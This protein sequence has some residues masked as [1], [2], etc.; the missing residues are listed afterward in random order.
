M[1]GKSLIVELYEQIV[2]Y[3]KSFGK[4]IKVN[5][6][7]KKEIISKIKT[8]TSKDVFFQ[9]KLLVEQITVNS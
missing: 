8:L 2:A 7:T 9:K 4:E 1:V 3:A 6:K 5:V